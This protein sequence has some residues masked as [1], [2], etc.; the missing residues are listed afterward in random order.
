[1]G[2]ETVLHLRMV[3]AEEARGAPTPRAFFGGLQL[4]IF[5]P[6]ADYKTKFSIFVTYVV[7][8]RYG[9]ER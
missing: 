2:V 6:F 3:P 5:A 4:S 8:V 1:M 9:V 7:I